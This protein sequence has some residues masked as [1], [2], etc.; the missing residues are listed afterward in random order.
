MNPS[1]KAGE[2]EKVFEGI[3]KVP[4]SENVKPEETEIGSMIYAVKPGDGSARGAG[5]QLPE[6]TRRACQY[7]QRIRNETL[8]LQCNELG[9]DT[10]SD[11]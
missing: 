8:P 3:R 1:E 5:R 2:L 6:G 7:R 9:D 11:G 4:G 10:V